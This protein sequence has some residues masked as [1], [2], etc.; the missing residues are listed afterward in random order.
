MLLNLLK[1]YFSNHP[2]NEAAFVKGITMFSSGIIIVHFLMV[3]S[4]S[5]CNS[6]PVLNNS[7]L[8]IIYFPSF[9]QTWY[10]AYIFPK[11]I[12]IRQK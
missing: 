4:L 7:D 3:E 12:W 6:V 1:S 2:N 10:K 11:N 9:K 5:T 8:N